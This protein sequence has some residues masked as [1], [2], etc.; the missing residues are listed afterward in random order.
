MI[1]TTPYQL[2]LWPYSDALGFSIVQMA[3][4]DLAFDDRDV[5]WLLVVVLIVSSASLSRAAFARAGG[6]HCPWD[7]RRRR[8]ARPRWNLTGEISASNGTNNFSQTLLAQLPEPA[9][10]A[11][12]GDRRQADDLPRPAASPTRRG[13]G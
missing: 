1:L 3:N 5:T 8:R 6:T 4:R 12:Q 11:R 9:E 13:S 10:L 2:D 7:R